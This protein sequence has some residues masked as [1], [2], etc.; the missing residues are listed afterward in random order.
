M[1]NR[2]PTIATPLAH[3]G[4]SPSSQA[5]ALPYWGRRLTEGERVRLMSSHET[6]ALLCG[7]FL[8]PRHG[9][10]ASATRGA[11]A[12]RRKDCSQTRGEPQFSDCPFTA[13]ARI[14][15]DISLI[16]KRARQRRVPGYSCSVGAGH[17]SPLSRRRS[18]VRSRIC[19]ASWP[20]PTCG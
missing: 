19:N 6:N 5:I 8:D 3:R 14:I 7:K 17:A 16:P 11:G 13:I 20:Q 1:S 4:L 9:H 12:F 18:S 2:T 15:A 10:P